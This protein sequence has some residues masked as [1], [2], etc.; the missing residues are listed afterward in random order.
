MSCIFD[1]ERVICELQA[2]AD[3]TVEHS[4]YNEV[5]SDGSTPVDKINVYLLV[6]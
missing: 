5:Q 2:K 6:E 1:T 3:E 4:T